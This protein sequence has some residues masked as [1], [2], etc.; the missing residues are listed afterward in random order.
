MRIGLT[1]AAVLFAGSFMEMAGMASALFGR[2]GAVSTWMKNKMKEIEE[3][4]KD[5]DEE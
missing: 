2:K 5:D 3:N 4:R 1:T